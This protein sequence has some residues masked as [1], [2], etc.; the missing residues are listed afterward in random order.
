MRGSR[1]INFLME[2]GGWE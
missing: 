2:P 1:I